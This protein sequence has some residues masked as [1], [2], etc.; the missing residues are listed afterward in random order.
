MAAFS[1]DRRS[2]RRYPIQLPVRY[3]VIRKD[4]TNAEGVGETR[5][6]SSGGIALASDAE[7]PP[8]SIIE[9]WVTWPVVLD[10]VS[11]VELHIAGLVV[12]SSGLEAA[13]QMKRHEFETCRN[14]PG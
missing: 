10:S 13:I 14:E 5:N 12:R 2:N 7:L 1:G 8:S 4:Q 6:I 11:C 3:R 9:L